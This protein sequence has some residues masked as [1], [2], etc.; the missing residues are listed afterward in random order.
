MLLLNRTCIMSL[1]SAKTK[2]WK[3]SSEMTNIRNNSVGILNIMNLCSILLGGEWGSCVY[4]KTQVVFRDKNSACYFIRSVTKKASLLG[5]YSLISCSLI[6]HKR[7]SNPSKTT[8]PEL[9]C[10]TSASISPLHSWRH[11]CF[12]QKE[13]VL[14]SHSSRYYHRL[15]SSTACE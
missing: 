14:L 12:R 2:H 1:Q 13:W 6:I 7:T 11:I 8:S 4:C 10:Y 3:W 5:F 15:V 9:C